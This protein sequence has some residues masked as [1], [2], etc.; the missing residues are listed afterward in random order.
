MLE[1][2]AN[3]FAGKAE[4]ISGKLHQ[5]FTVYDNLALIGSFQQV[6]TAHKGTLSRPGKA[7]NP[8]DVSLPDGKAYI[9]HGVYIVETVFKRTFSP[10]SFCD[11]F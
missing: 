5:V 3:L 4:I 1:Y 6:D 8:E 9:P 7:D 11:V 2:H 10:K